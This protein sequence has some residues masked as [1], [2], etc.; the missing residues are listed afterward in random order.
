MIYRT[1]VHQGKK[2][3]KRISTLSYAEVEGNH[4][5]AIDSVEAI[6][7]PLPPGS[8]TVTTNLESGNRRDVLFL[9]TI[10]KT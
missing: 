9:D 3:Y 6:F 4:Q 10:H 7:A 2:E 8:M 1:V 5:T